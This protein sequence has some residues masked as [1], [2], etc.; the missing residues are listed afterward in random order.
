VL[1]F[2]RDKHDAGIDH[3]ERACRAR[4]HVDHAALLEGPAIVDAT[5]NGAA[6]IGDGNHAA[7]RPGPVRAGHLAG[8]ADAFVERGEA[9]FRFCAGHECNESERG[10][11][12]SIQGGT[13]GALRPTDKLR[14][15]VPVPGDI[16]PTKPRVTEPFCELARAKTPAAT[17][18][19]DFTDCNASWFHRARGPECLGARAS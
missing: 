6:L 18:T 7:E 5:A 2:Q 12:R 10:E 11:K 15:L 4:R 14:E 1:L 16:S 8:K 9:A 17:R 3:A 19:P 13:I